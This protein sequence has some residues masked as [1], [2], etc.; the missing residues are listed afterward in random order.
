V[1]I[2][3]WF[4]KNSITAVVALHWRRAHIAGFTEEFKVWFGAQNLDTKTHHRATNS[5]S[6]ALSRSLVCLALL[7]SS[8]NAVARAP[9][10]VLMACANRQTWD[11]P[12]VGCDSDQVLPSR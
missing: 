6:C 11:A 8:N 4:S 2:I 5:W 12:F 9:F 10:S 3:P 7:G 1:F